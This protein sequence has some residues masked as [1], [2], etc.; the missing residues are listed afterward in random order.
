[1][2]NRVKKKFISLRQQGRMARK[3]YRMMKRDGFVP[4]YV[5][6]IA[7]GGLFL[8]QCLSH[9]FNVELVIVSAV[10][11]HDDERGEINFSRYCVYITKPR[12]TVLVV[13]D[14]TDSGITLVKTERYLMRKFPEI[15]ELAGGCRFGDC[16]HDGEPGCAVLA[17]LDD[18]TLDPDRLEGW[19]RIRA[20]SENA[21]LRADTAAYRQTARSWGRIYR[22]AQSL[23]RR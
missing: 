12:G 1:M 17:A 8:G 5:V 22:D 21:A 15:E 4:D 16:R 9:W 23:K 14:L 11:Y 19:R 6:A 2:R 10:S 13:D 7:R 20:A 18:G 3:L